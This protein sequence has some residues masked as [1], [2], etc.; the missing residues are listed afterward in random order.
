MVSDHT[1]AENLEGVELDGGWHV[2][3]KLVRGDDATGGHFSVGY[4][5]E[6]TDGQRGFLKAL[7]YARVFGGANPN[8]ALEMMT[9]D[10]NYEVRL[11]EKC[12]TERMNRIVSVLAHGTTHVG[13]FQIG[14]VSYLVFEWA[15]GDVR[16]AMVTDRWLEASAV[17]R[18]LHD[19][20]VG[21]EQLHRHRL[22]HRDLKPSNVLMM[23]TTVAKIA[24]LGRAA[25][26]DHPA[27]FDPDDEMT[28]AGDP[29]YAPPEAL[30]GIRLDEPDD[31]RMSC[32]AYLLGS[33]TMFLT[34]KV[35]TTAGL[36]SRLHPDH[37]RDV[38]VG[39]YEDALPYIRDAFDRLV[40]EY[41]SNLLPGLED[42]GAI[43]RQLCE[44]DPKLRGHP[45]NRAGAGS[46]YAL[47]RYVA[48]FNL[49]A[50]RAELG[51]VGKYL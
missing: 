44:P 48:W 43:V 23:P 7:D 24:D 3:R 40:A 19:V 35:S 16:E 26:A 32:D 47:Q 49:L 6:R 2:V 17:L 10:F 8:I 30:Y 41:E 29:A 20:T 42:L 13:G 31:R 33:L 34:S 9:S 46:S 18:C 37:W 27:P 28:V 25:Y 36:R 51:L 15:D 12:A 45:R 38:W 4:E 22:T 5:V 21:L 39:S 14:A 11:L 1:A 50:V